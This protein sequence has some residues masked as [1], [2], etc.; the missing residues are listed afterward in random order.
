METKWDYSSVLV[1]PWW[2]G[3]GQWGKNEQDG[4]VLAKSLR[5]GDS[6]NMRVRVKDTANEETPG[7][8]I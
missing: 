3:L 6:W 7:F 2:L 5:F 4:G 1:R 8:F